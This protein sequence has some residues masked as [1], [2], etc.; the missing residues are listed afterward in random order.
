MA[1]FGRAHAAQA[2]L[3]FQLVNLLEYRP[4]GNTEM[5]SKLHGSNGIILTN[6]V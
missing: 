6:Q 5:L 4:L 1:A 3:A 2:A